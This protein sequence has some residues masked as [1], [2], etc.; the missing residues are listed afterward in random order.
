MRIKDRSALLVLIIGFK[1]CP[2][3]FLFCIFS[4]KRL[5][6]FYSINGQT[7]QMSLSENGNFGTR[8]GW[9]IST[10]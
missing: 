4:S 5:D 6:F 1:K 7:E 9:T 3:S 8:T 2:C 10:I